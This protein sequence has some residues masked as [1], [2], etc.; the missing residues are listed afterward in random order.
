MTHEQSTNADVEWFVQRWLAYVSNHGS[1]A[2]FWDS[3]ASQVTVPVLR[4]AAR[5]LKIKAP[6]KTRAGLRGQFATKWTED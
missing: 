2:W 5:V 3:I 1:F 6:A 4:D